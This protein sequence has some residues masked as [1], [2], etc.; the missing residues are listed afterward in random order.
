MLEA[1]VD[2]GHLNVT[3]SLYHCQMGVLHNR[4]KSYLK[5]VIIKYL[6][7]LGLDMISTRKISNCGSY[8]WYHWEPIGSPLDTESPLLWVFFTFSSPGQK[9]SCFC[10]FLLL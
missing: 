2:L 8:E 4:V 3:D 5:S 1:I 10:V 6:C 9:D 7:F